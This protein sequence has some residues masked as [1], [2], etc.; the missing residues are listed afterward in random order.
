LNLYNPNSFSTVRNNY[1][2]QKIKSVISQEV[3]ADNTQKEDI[4]LPVKQ[5]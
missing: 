4:Y 5:T 1:P 3:N 2:T